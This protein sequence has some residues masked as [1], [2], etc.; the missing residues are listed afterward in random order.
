MNETRQAPTD[1]S[2]KYYAD[3]PEQQREGLRLFRAS[4]P[5]RSKSIEGCDWEYRVVGEGVRPLLWLPGAL[6][7]SDSV[8]PQA[9]RFASTFRVIVPSYPPLQSTTALV[10]GLATL[11]AA[12]GAQE[13]W[14]VGGSYGGMVAQALVRRHPERVRSL[15][16]SHT[17]P[18]DRGRGMKA[19]VASPLFALLPEGSLRRMYWRRMVALIP[20]QRTEVAWLLGY[21]A[22]LVNERLVKEDIVAL[23]RRVADYDTLDFDPGDLKGW[24]GRVLLVMSADDPATPEPVRSR[25]IELYPGAEVQVF[26]GTGH[27]SAL[28]RPDS[29]YG[30]LTAFLE[31]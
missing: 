15:V 22:E 5:P 10:D 4:H 27:A 18:P 19:R 16:L 14:V 3:V 11:L 13:A 24:R 21:L 9:E 31:S 8:W 28:L 1:P 12:E 20:E 23:Y 17:L 6:L 26:R 29:Y 25:M 7:K 2:A 30:A